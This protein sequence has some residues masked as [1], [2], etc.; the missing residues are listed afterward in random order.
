MKKK[1]VSLLAPLPLLST[2]PPMPAFLARVNHK[3]FGQ[4]C[5][6]VNY[7]HST[8]SLPTMRYPTTLLTGKW[9]LQ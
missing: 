8:N 2:P 5:C 1:S 3:I 6:M 4:N 7:S 9:F